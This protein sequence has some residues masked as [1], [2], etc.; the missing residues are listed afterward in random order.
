LTRRESTKV[1][2]R[3]LSLR[4]KR[5]QLEERLTFIM[6]LAA[7]VGCVG[8][9]GAIVFRLMISAIQTVFFSDLL[10]TV[11]VYVW[12]VNLGIM[13]LPALGGLIIG[14]VVYDIAPETR[15]TGIPQ[16]MEAY[17]ME[18]GRI[19]ARIALLKVLVSSV[20]LGSGGSAGRE[21]PITQIGAAAGSAWVGC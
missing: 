20:T 2:D 13:L 10:P 16:V 7:L 14:V 4:G 17:T 5:G 8:G 1:S 6:V 11:T 21:G 19:R 18:G 15:G 3:I 9:V 12:N